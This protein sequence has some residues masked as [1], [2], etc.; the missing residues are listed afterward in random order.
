MI[1]ASIEGFQLSPQQRRLWR[2]S[3]GCVDSIYRSHC[4]I[5]IEGPLDVDVLREAFQ[6]VITRHEI[7]RTTFLLL[8][9]FTLPLQVI[10]DNASFTL[11]EHDL[12]HLDFKHQ[13]G[14]L[15]EIYS[16]VINYDF[17]IKQDQLLEASLVRL[18]Y[19]KHIVII[20]LPAFWAERS[21]LRLLARDIIQCYAAC[22][23]G[24]E[25]ADAS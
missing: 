15:E 19:S 8:S 25:P 11:Q 24:L 4:S 7:V 13:S 20:C 17:Q 18:A 14:R 2:L 5:N 10:T 12:S 23:L 3:G 9:D 21:P 1:E 16:E 22:S 6:E